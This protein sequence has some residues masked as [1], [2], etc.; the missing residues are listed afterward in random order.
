LGR[1]NYKE[2]V[3][4]S[5]AVAAD[6][7]RDRGYRQYLAG[8]TR[9]VLGVDFRLDEDRDWFA[10]AMKAGG[11]VMPKH[12]PMPD[13]PVFGWRPFAQ[14]RPDH[15]LKPRRVT[16]RHSGLMHRHRDAAELAGRKGRCW[17]GE[18]HLYKPIKRRIKDDRPDRPEWVTRTDWYQPPYGA[19]DRLRHERSLC[20]WAD[21]NVERIIREQFGVRVKVLDERVR[22]DGTRQVLLPTGHLHPDTGDQVVPVGKIH[23]HLDWAKYLYVKGEGGAQRLSTHPWMLRDNFAAPEGLFFF[24]IEGT[25]KLDA[26]VSAGW[27]GIESGSVTLWDAYDED[28]VDEGAGAIGYHELADFATRHL[29]GVPTAIVCDSDWSEN[30]L[31]REQVDKAVRVLRD[32]GVDAVG[33]AP[34][35]GDPLNWTFEDGTVLYKK[36]GVDDY[37]AAEK[38]ARRHDLLLDMPIRLTE[39]TEAMERH[40]KRSSDRSD[41]QATDLSL[42]HELIGDA[43]TDGLVSYNRGS[44][45]ERMGR[46]PRRVDD[47]RDR[48][49]AEGALSFVASHIRER[50]GTWVTRPALYRLAD[51]LRPLASRTLRDWLSRT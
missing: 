48:L 31:V 17:C 23:T 4:T 37:L 12:A 18:V 44:L 14:L 19:E 33:C 20:E 8:E 6:V 10:S 51:D 35:P 30:R 34:P 41:G 7:A 5:R 27:P 29:E 40:A 2:A 21:V 36:Q 50:P 13:H 9:V 47:S 46:D 22:E 32:A 26:V 43:G 28:P 15:P 3:F 11:W 38:K 39:T 16:H 49:L 42:L 1:D 24:V 25:L 45:A